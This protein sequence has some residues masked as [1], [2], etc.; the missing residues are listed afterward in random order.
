MASEDLRYYRE[1]A[2]AELEL[3]RQADRQDVAAIHE[4]LARCY[5][6]LLD[7]RVP[8]SNPWDFAT[9]QQAA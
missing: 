7:R 6:T 1:R 3:A 2:A 8:A 5:L 4:E 9:D